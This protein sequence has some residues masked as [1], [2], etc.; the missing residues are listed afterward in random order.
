MDS[1]S[2]KLIQLLDSS[3]IDLRMSAIRIACEIGLDSKQVIHSLARCLREEPEALRV[4]AL[5]A[6]A[7]LGAREVVEIVVP[8]ILETGP[9]GDHARRVV[10]AAGQPAVHHLAAL[11]GKADF[12]GKSAIAATL[13]QIGGRSSIEF[14]LGVLPGESF[15][16]Q[17]Q[18]TRCICDCLDAM[19]AAGQVPLY[20][21]VL[22]TL[23]SKRGQA[24]LQV[25]VACLI[26]LGYFHGER[27]ARS[28]QQV[29]LRHT[30][31][32]QPGEVRRHALVSYQRLLGEAPL[33]AEQVATLE[34][35]LCDE[36]WHN[37]AQ[38]ALAAFQRVELSRPH[39]L[40]LVGLLHKSPHFSV[41]IHIFERLRGHDSREVVRAIIP[42]LSD[43]RF[44]VRDAAEAALRSLPSAI[45]D[46]FKALLE[47]EDSEV[48][49]RISSILRDYPQE[50]KKRFS[51]P[52]TRLFL[53]LFDQNDGRYQSFFDFVQGIDPEP[54]RARIYQKVRSLK[55]GRSKEKW[56]KIAGYLQIL[57][58]HHLITT[59][60]RYLFAVAL[61]H[62][63]NRDLSPPARR[64]NLGLRVIRALIYDDSPKLID[65]LTRDRDVGPEEVFYI[66]FHFMEEGE[67][68]R[69]FA[70]ALLTHL[71]RKYPKS[72]F[73][74]PARGKLELH[75]V[76]QK[77][78]P[79][80]SA[81]RSGPQAAGAPAK[82]PPAA[83]KREKGKPAPV[84]A[85][86]KPTPPRAPVPAA[87]ARPA[88]APPR[89]TKKPPPRRV[90]KSA[91]RPR[92]PPRAAA[93]KAPPPR[94][95]K[96]GQKKGR[97]KG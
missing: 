14:L 82:A 53:N 59:E 40:K 28:A 72:K 49:Q 86:A 16:L 36:D 78:A 93:R 1:T 47:L 84:A 30:D 70:R 29:L 61:I 41:H 19:P 71:L 5:T 80:P 69:P 32:R 20:R 64:A 7:R 55:S 24:D 89:G 11:Y 87:P 85:A 26:L 2:K 31:R 51:E 75:I 3:N 65:S 91:T 95:R 45:E 96:K 94:S 15:E 76:G 21:M 42:F 13:A 27:L 8:M 90:P 67:E 92:V 18:V 23:S 97:S 48:C 6:L 56:I 63:G 44:R 39:V 35:L 17:K 81:A 9:L 58:D 34:K 60:G 25:Q 74:A 79:T 4:L 68:M 77:P 88:K 10:A 73:A 46:L 38:H 12:H 33:G 43:S 37:V 57:W 62:L 54:I 50:A 52:A 66:G 22:R 83:A